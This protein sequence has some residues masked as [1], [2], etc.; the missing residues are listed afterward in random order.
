MSLSLNH[1]T[2]APKNQDHIL[3]A[4]EKRRQQ[5]HV[6]QM[7]ESYVNQSA[8]RRV[9]ECGQT[10]TMLEDVAGTAR[11]YDTGY[12]CGHRMC[13]ACAWRKSMGTAVVISAIAGALVAQ[14][15]VPLMVTLTAPN[16][17]GE[18]LGEEIR[19]YN[20]AWDKLIRRT[21]YRAAWGDNIRKLEVTYNAQDDTYHPHLHVLVFVRPSYFNGR[22]YIS[23]KQLLEDWRVCYGNANITQ[24]DIRKS[25][26]ADGKSI[27]EISKYVAKSSDYLQ[28]QRV[29]NAFYAGLRG[30]RLIGYSGRC[31]ELREVFKGGGLRQYVDRD[32]TQYVWR[33][34]YRDMGDGDYVEQERWHYDDVLEDDSGIEIAAAWAYMED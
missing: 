4:V 23:R 17:E 11:R 21:K 32:L 13:P 18:Q 14:Q 16:C 8:Y 27:A 1:N 2:I 15:R 7:L 5:L 19:R 3:V 9:L 6:A 10:V 22:T 24:V 29:F 31:K 30:K 25:Y 28:S 26:G 12:F 33:V 20:R 34:L